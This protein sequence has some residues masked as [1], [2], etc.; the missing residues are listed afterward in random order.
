M[1]LVLVGWTL[2]EVVVVGD[3]QRVMTGVDLRDE[4]FGRSVER[5]L[6]WDLLLL[7][8]CALCVVLGL[9]RPFAEELVQGLS[10]LLQ[11]Y[12]L[13]KTMFLDFLEWKWWA[14]KVAPKE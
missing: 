3:N 9:P 13:P 12:T 1:L 7:G 8:L 14:T 4:G 2:S 5:D 11:R 6:L 10:F